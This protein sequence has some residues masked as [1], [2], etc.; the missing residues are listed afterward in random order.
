MDQ[1]SFSDR[2][3]LITV[4]MIAGLGNLSAGLIMDIGSRP[5]GSW[6]CD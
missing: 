3:R 4:D 6:F 5:G 1:A 2:D